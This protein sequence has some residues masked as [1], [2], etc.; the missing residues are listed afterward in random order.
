MLK[1]TPVASRR[2]VAFLFIDFDGLQIG[3]K[4]L[5]LVLSLTHPGVDWIKRQKSQ[6]F[7]GPK[8]AMLKFIE[9]HQRH[10]KT[11]SYL[12]TYTCV[13]KVIQ[14]EKVT[15]CISQIHANPVNILSY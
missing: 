3:L 13:L 5:V 4:G 1:G 14:K 15:Y 10:P 8:Q 2:N 9:P 12:D 6:E 7:K 11:K